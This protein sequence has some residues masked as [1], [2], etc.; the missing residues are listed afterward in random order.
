MSLYG[1]GVI[2]LPV[3]L[4]GQNLSVFR[5]FMKTCELGLA[6]DL[7]E[8]KREEEQLFQVN[9]CSHCDDCTTAV[10]YSQLVKPV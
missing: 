5:E 10:C 8:Q 7:E 2:S 4:A 3:L 6:E 1:H 9:F